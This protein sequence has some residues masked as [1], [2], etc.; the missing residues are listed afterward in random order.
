MANQ[1]LDPSA[2]MAA[3]PKAIEGL[4][5][6]EDL[7]KSISAGLTE[8]AEVLAI[9]NFTTTA[10]SAVEV[11]TSYLQTMDSLREK[12]DTTYKSAVRLFEATNAAG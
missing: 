5:D 2:Y 7:I 3:Y 9:P 4:S 12:V 10:N 8:T 6:A 1:K 11:L